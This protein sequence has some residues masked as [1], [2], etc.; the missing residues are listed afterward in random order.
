MKTYA[1]YEGP[2]FQIPHGDSIIDGQF[3]DRT[4]RQ[5]VDESLGE[6]RLSESRRGEGLDARFLRHR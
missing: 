1:W 6:A 4:V 2:N 3:I 5:A